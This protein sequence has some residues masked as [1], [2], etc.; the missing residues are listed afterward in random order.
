[1]NKWQK[2]ESEKRKLQ[3]L[4]LSSKEYQYRIKKLCYELR[5]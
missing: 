2:Y 1:M 4:N 5:V 3:I